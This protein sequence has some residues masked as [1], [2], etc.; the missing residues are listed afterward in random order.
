MRP[1]TLYLS[2]EPYF[3]Y[4]SALEPGRVFEGQAPERWRPLDEDFA[5][6]VPKRARTPRGFH[7]KGFSEFDPQDPA[8]EAIW[9]GPRFVAPLLGLCEATAGEIIVAAR[10]YFADEP[11]VNRLYFAAATHLS[12][13]EALAAWRCCLETGDSMAH[14]AIGY[15]L[16]ELERFREAYAHLRHYVE[17]APH[18]AWNW[19][20]LGRG[21]AAIGETAEA[22]TA[23]ERAIAL[24]GQGDD[25]TD[26]PELL[27]ELAT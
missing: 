4:L 9:S 22:R 7:V 3:D 16:F 14:F 20:W 15:T 1:T 5:F 23:Y 27:A 19:C 21:A 17:I 12:G 24:T 25:E 2:R 11:S 26:A 6:Y 18:A 8:L 10:A 13:E